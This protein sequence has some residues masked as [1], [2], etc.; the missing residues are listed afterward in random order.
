MKWFDYRQN[1]SGGS[2]VGPQNVVVQATSSHMADAAAVEF[3]GVYFDGC[4][5]EVDCPC[6]GDRWSR[7]WDD[8]ED[9]PMVY[10]EAVT[11]GPNVLLVYADGHTEGGGFGR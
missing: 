7:S 11:A 1:N 5:D 2:F 9:Q 3:G 8:G 10:G 6:C 4:A